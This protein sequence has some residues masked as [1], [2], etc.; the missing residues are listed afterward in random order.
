MNTESRRLRNQL[1]LFS[2]LLILSSCGSHGVLRSTACNDSVYVALKH[3][4][5]DSMSAREFEYFQRKDKE[6]SEA[7]VATSETEHSGSALPVIIA[8]V[9]VIS[10]LIFIGRLVIQ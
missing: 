7:V 4:P 6:C 8:T 1:W 5:L 3:K 10:F 2:A 9:L